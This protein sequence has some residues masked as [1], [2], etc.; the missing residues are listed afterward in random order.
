MESWTIP[1]AALI[2]SITTLILTVINNSQRNDREGYQELE[3]EVQRLLEERD[4]LLAANEASLREVELLR[5]LNI[6]QQQLSHKG[7]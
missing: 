6:E 5:K 1:L 3:S 7:R 4:K 2:V